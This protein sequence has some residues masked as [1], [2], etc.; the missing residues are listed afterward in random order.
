[1]FSMPHGLDP[2]FTKGFIYHTQEDTGQ[3][4]HNAL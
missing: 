4:V 2:K 1:M 3:L